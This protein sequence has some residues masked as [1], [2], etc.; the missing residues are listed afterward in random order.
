MRALVAFVIA[1]AVAACTPS[2]PAGVSVTVTV[3]VQRPHVQVTLDGAAF[4]PGGNTAHAVSAQYGYDTWD[5]AMVDTHAVSVT[6]GGAVL[7]TVT[8]PSGRCVAACAAGGCVADDVKYEWSAV[9][10]DL[11][12][13]VGLAC[14]MCQ[15]ASGILVTDCPP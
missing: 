11:Q 2:T 10:V 4:D 15:S 12:G 13:K 6:E 14:L 3:D 9:A 7:G 5:Q 8:V 1:G